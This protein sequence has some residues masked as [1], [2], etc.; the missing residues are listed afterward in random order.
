M[1]S[2]LPSGGGGGGSG[3]DPGDGGSS[4]SEYLKENFIGADGGV[5]WGDLSG[6]IIGGIITA[7]AAGVIT[8][9]QAVGVVIDQGLEPI[10][11]AARDGGSE[12]ASAIIYASDAWGPMDA[13]PLSLPVNVAFLLAAMFLLAWV[14]NRAR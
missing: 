7:V 8:V 13:G 3:S 2:I 12:V 6:G 11:Q 9:Q 1:A 10:Q 14:I 4:L 5:Q